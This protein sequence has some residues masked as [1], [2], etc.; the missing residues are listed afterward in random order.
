M[1]LGGIS[2]SEVFS[3][4]EVLSGSLGQG[5]MFGLCTCA[6]AC[7]LIDKINKFDHIMITSPMRS[8][9]MKQP[10]CNTKISNIPNDM[11]HEIVVR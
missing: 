1:H 9:M 4:E 5:V 11:L 6:I 8:I 3:T 10:F 7:P 2:S